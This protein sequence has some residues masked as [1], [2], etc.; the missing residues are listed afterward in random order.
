[1]ICIVSVFK[2]EGHAIR[3]WIDHHIKEG[4]DT[5]FLTD[6]G[7]TDTYNIQDYI[8]QKI[9]VL[10]KD[11]KRYSQLEHLN[12][13]LKE[14]KQYDWVIVIDLD[15]FIYSRRGF[16][17]VK[18]YLNTVPKDIYSIVLPWK[19]FG[20]NGHVNQPKSI[21][22]G[23]TKRNNTNN[24]IKAHHFI[25]SITRGDKLIKINIHTSPVQGN[26][27]GFLPV[28][29][30]T[31]NLTNEEVLNKSYI[32]LNHY[33]IQSWD[34]FKNVKMTRGDCHNKNSDKV[35]DEN[36]FKKYDTNDILDVELKNKHYN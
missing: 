33:A 14:S 35:R 7:S 18:D 29:L 21:I 6:N 24:V 31:Q 22:Q 11:P 23:F 9:V 2:N 20:S 5:F 13:Y 36:Y 1:M 16:K 3:E 28:P 32:H 10:R 26:K 27:K 19:M 17:T 25:K 12:Y 4:V 8:D 15:E 34:F 30:Y